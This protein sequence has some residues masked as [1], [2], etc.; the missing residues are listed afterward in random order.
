MTLD[1][2]KQALRKQAAAA[3]GGLLATAR[4]HAA[5]SLRDLFC[6]N[7]SL[8]AGAIVSAFWPAKG[9]I[10]VLPL[11]RDLF[12]RGYMCALPVVIR[13]GQALEFRCWTPATALVPGNFGIPV[14]PED[15]E[16]VRPDVLLVPLLAFDR[17]GHR[18]G[19]GAGFYDRTLAGLRAERAVLAIGI[20]F[21]AQEV[22]CVPHGPH[23]EPLDWVVTED[24]AIRT[25]AAQ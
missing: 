10:D 11:V 7:I 14:P 21:A 24:E 1:L 20:A 13:R 9:E 17:A 25:R 3:R 4:N 8:S 23:D 6:A 16:R 22:D 15:C 2:D 18:L 12:D 19:W 5:S